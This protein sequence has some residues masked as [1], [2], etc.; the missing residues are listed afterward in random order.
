MDVTPL[1]KLNPHEDGKTIVVRVCRIWRPKKFQTENEYQG[2]E[3]IFVD[4][5]VR[6]LNFLLPLFNNKF[7]PLTAD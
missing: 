5:Q 6:I 1:Q 2:L 4:A 7:K 3:A